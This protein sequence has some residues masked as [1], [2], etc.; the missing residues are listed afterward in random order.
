MATRFLSPFRVELIDGKDQSNDGRGS[1]AMCAP[2]GVWSEALQRESWVPE[3]FVHDFAS[4][5]RAP[6]VF[7]R[8]G[9]RAHRAAPHHDLLYTTHE[10]DRLTADSVFLELM[11]ATGVPWEIAAEMFRAVRLFGDRRWDE[12]GQAQPARV[13]QQ[14]APA[15]A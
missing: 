2:F 1:W 14:F 6:L 9:D 4:L 7:L 12:P 11:L 10:V 15:L 5:P 8:Y 3:G 13:V